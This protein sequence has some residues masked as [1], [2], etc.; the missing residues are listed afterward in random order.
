MA[1]AAPKA[2]GSTPAWVLLLASAVRSGD[3][4]KHYAMFRAGRMKGYNLG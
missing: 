2:R 1:P 4:G 3:G